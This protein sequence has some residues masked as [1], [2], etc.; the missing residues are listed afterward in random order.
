MGRFE[1]GE[2]Y[3]STDYTVSESFATG[4]VN[5]ISFGTLSLAAGG[6][7]GF[8]ELRTT[9]TPNITATLIIRNSY[10]LGN[11]NADRVTAT[12][13]DTYAGGLVGRITEGFFYT[14]P[15]SQTYR[16][17]RSFATGSVSAR[18]AGS[19]NLFAGGI[20]GEMNFRVVALQGFLNNT[21]ALGSSVTAMGRGTINIGRVFGS[22]TNT[23]ASN[24]FARNNI[25][26]GTM[27]SYTN[28]PY[29]NFTATT[30]V[31][32]LTGQ[33]GEDRNSSQF[34]SSAFWTGNANGN[35]GLPTSLWDFSSV[36]RGYPKLRNL[37]GQ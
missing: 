33:H 24:N 32:S 2:R 31:S 30:V 7:I 12:S 13:G 16:I 21:A 10:A 5:A 34:V 1:G 23:T 15:S 8:L 11:V 19:G 35:M 37:G 14:N 6:L 25:F 4:N 3:I 36:S 22:L 18:S 28:N 27:N 17:E 29:P 26:V 9:D 20:V